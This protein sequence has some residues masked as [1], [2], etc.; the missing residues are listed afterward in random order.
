MA[1]TVILAGGGTGGHV[2]PALAMGDAMRAR[3]H[4]VLYYG[5]AARLEGRVAPTRG[6]RFRG[7][8]AAQFPRAGLAAKV[9]FAL[10]LWRSVLQA[11]RLLKEDGASLVL[12]VGGY[13]MAPTVLAAWTLGIPAVIHEANVAPGLANRLCARVAKL[14]LLTYPETAA[15]LPGTAEKQVVG[16][17]V[18]PTVLTS[19]R[20]AAA[21]RY[22]FDPARPVLVAVG[23]SL[24]AAKLN[25]LTIALARDPARA[26]QLL[27]VTGPRY[28]A[29]VTAAYG[30]P[31]PEG[32]ALRGYEDRMADAFAVADLVL[33]RSGSSTLA[34]L[35]AVGCASV[36]LPSPNVTDN[37]QEENARGLERAGAA[38]VVVE[39]GMDVAAVSAK[40]RAL[41]ADAPRRTAM[42]Q[43]ARKLA[44]LEVAEEV[45]TM[46]EARFVAP[47]A[48]HPSP[49]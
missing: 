32:V 41:M 21:D 49:T 42:A 2:Y 44:R 25:E 40:I 7:V 45:A 5:D 33:C 24:G 28:E 35:C 30:T 14:V 4:T 37:H 16:C 18:N 43:A 47:A 8:D 20:Y 15:R 13:V 6:Y 10:S 29:E 39:A 22:G 38:E 26:F 31:L 9:R 11:R 19:D 27:H 36:L 34:E 48:P 17:P 46:L 1:H 23:G 12:G 3:G